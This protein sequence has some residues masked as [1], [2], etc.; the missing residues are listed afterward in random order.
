ML[1]RC[2][3]ILLMLTS[4]KAAGVLI[5]RLVQLGDRAEMLGK[6]EEKARA[7]NA[8]QIGGNHVLEVLL[9]SSYYVKLADGLQ[10]GKGFGS[11]DP[12]SDIREERRILLDGDEQEWRAY[13]EL[14]ADAG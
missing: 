7:H 12:V 4:S 5:T 13:S 14:V 1:V 6:F 8:T 10:G 3:T 2:D 11:K 9:E